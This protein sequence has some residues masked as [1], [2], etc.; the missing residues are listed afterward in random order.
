MELPS[1]TAPPTQLSLTESSGER[2]DPVVHATQE[3]PIVA[4]AHSQI[5]VSSH[6]QF[7]ASSHS[8]VQHELEPDPPASK[9]LAAVDHP[10]PTHERPSPGARKAHE[11]AGTGGGEESTS[12]LAATANTS[13]P[14]DTGLHD[15]EENQRRHKLL[16]ERHSG[17]D[18]DDPEMTES[19]S[20]KD[21][22]GAML[23][24]NDDIESMAGQSNDDVDVESLDVPFSKATLARM[25]DTFKTALYDQ[26]VGREARH[27][28]CT[29]AGARAA[30]NVSFW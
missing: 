7:V 18:D 30:G 5:V 8:Q 6:S 1:T 12:H 24:A 29:V 9:E 27:V 2:Q 15:N 26:H 22:E 11:D 4:Q 23:A 21:E 10:S 19:M 20:T 25:T 16:I 17:D 13:D 3:L 14:A 28:Y